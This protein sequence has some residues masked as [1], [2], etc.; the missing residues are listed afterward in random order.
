MGLYVETG[1]REAALRQYQYCVRVLQR[2]LGIE[3]ETVTKA[4]YQDI[5]RQRPRP[6][7]SKTSAARPELLA[8]RLPAGIETELIGRVQEMETLSEELAGACSGAGRVV[9]ILGE[10]GIGRVVSSAKSPIS[11]Q[12][13]Y[14]GSD[15][16]VLRVGADPAL[17]SLGQCASRRS[18]GRRRRAAIRARAPRFVPRSRASCPRSHGV[19]PRTARRPTCG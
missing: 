11:G 17:R 2:E 12:P 8:E 13:W 5:L 16:A 9:A 14:G 18:S 10:A 19:A 4:L 7:R 3:P 6:S 15:R 1:R